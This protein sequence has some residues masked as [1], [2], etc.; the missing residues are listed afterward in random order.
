MCCGIYADGNGA[1]GFLETSG[2][3]YGAGDVLP[4][5]LETPAF[6]KFPRNIGASLWGVIWHVELMLDTDYK[7]ARTEYQNSSD[8]AYIHLLTNTDYFH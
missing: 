8:D 2:V 1:A 4:A 3:A 7:N 5:E 6:Q